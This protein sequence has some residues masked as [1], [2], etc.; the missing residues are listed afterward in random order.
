M[1]LTTLSSPYA[2][3]VYMGDAKL[4]KTTWL[5]ASLLGALPH[6]TESVVS[7]PENLHILGLDESWGEGLAE[8][9]RDVCKRPASWLNVSVHDLAE[10]RRKSG[11]ANGND[12]S[13]SNIVQAEIA[14]INAATAKPGVH[15]VV[16]SG[17]TGLAEGLYT[18]LAGLPGGTNEETGKVAKGGGMD[19]SKWQDLERQFIAARNRLQCNQHHVFWEA[20]IYMDKRLQGNQEVLVEALAAG[21]GGG[22][23][24]FGANVDYVFR[25]RREAAKHPGTAVDKVF[26]DTKP[27]MGTFTSGRKATLLD[28]KE[29]DLVTILKKL[30]KKTH[31]K[32]L[33]ATTA[34]KV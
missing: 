28:D 2:R 3:Q 15:A 22:G 12:Y 16:V 27:S 11:L 25:L 29:T 19:Q 26:V 6:Q 8:F 10:A 17:L 14:K 32:A 18:G 23:K 9:I 21:K 5:V 4:G 33:D 34:T 7:A 20:H 30:G 13:F 24:H 1:S 31:G